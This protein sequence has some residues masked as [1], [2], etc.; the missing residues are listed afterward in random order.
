MIIL[1]EFICFMNSYMN[2]R[3]PRFQMRQPET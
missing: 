3:V 1:H 2:L